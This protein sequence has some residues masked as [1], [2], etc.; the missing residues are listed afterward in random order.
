MKYAIIPVAAMGLLS[1]APASMNAQA[2]A[3]PAGIVQYASADDS[4]LQFQQLRKGPPVKP[5]T[6]ADIAGYL[7]KLDDVAQDFSA[8]FPAD[9]RRWDAMLT[10][11]QLAERLAQMGIPAAGPGVEPVAKQI[12]DAQD[13]PAFI[14]ES[15][16]FYLLQI[17]CAREGATA[18][19]EQNIAAF[20]AAYPTDARADFLRFYFAKKAQTSDPAKAEAIY[21]QLANSSNQQIAAQAAAALKMLNLAR[22]PLDLKFTALDGTSIDLNNMRGKVVLVDFWATWCGPCMREVPNVVAAYQKYHDQG[23]EVIGIS[24][25]HDSDAVLRVT[26]AK[27]MVWPQYFDGKGWQNSISTSF[28]IGSIPTMWLVGKD[29]LIADTQARDNLEPEIEKLLGQ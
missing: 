19:L 13:A 28:G 12:M 23:F 4:W 20:A 2:T 26:K 11:A 21:N 16:R 15:A 27:G 1:L 29:G 9:P 6:K 18:E 14:K 22:Q 8:R 24:L 7:S 17:A 3:E 10:G 5:T 25:D